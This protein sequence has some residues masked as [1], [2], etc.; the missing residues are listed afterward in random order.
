MKRQLLPL[1]T[2]VTPN[3]F[4]AELLTGQPADSLAGALKQMLLLH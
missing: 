4:E 2:V 1:A 3:S